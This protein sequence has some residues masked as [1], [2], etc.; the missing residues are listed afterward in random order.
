LSCF[1][2]SGYMRFINGVLLANAVGMVVLLLAMSLSACDRQKKTPGEV[3]VRVNGDNITAQQLEV[4][5]WHASGGKPEEG[6]M[7]QQVLRKQAIEALIDR[8][9]LLHEAVRNKIDRDPKVMQIVARLKTQAIVQAYLESK[10]VH[11]A[12]PSKADIDAYF[13]AHPEQ[14]AHRKV[15]DV[16]QLSISAQDFSAQLKAVMDASTSLDQVA[17]W[18]KRH[19]VA[20]ATTQL[21]YGSADLPQDIVGKLQGLG[22]NHLFV[23]HDGERDLLCAL[24]EFRD[25]PVTQEAAAEQIERL[26]FHQKMQEAAAAEITRLRA[27]A[28][29]DYL[30]KSAE[31]TV[32]EAPPADAALHSKPAA[33]MHKVALRK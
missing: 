20:Y 3:L 25:S 1:E 17:A 4:E 24:T 12:T 11:Q 30:D 21:S 23:M 27:S 28:K 32:E 8:Q 26:L 5:L 16:K 2:Q 7:R 6:A 29:V 31:P 13:Q 9:M 10:V 22:R 18:L 33:A 19:Q 15:L 14:F